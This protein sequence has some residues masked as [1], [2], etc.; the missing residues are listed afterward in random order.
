MRG[1]EEAGVSMTKEY[2]GDGCC[3]EMRGND[4][5]LTTENGIAATNTIVLEPEVYTAL[6]RFMQRQI[7]SPWS[8]PHQHGEETCAYGPGYNDGF[9]DGQRSR[10]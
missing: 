3:G 2:L 6:L 8:P 7:F 10:S 1:H 4:I 9:R 5:V